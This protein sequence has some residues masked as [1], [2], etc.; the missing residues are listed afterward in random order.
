M[1]CWT[2]G[3]T[4][5]IGRDLDEWAARVLADYDLETGWSLAHDSQARNGAL[6]VGN[7]LVGRTPFVLGG[8]YTVGNLVPLAL[9]DAAEKL[10]GLYGQMK[11]SPDGTQITLKNWV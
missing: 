10:G 3:K 5:V 4:E 8:E 6:P 9:A 11:D 7:R 1:A 2:N